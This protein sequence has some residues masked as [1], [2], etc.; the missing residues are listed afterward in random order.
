MNIQCVRCIEL[1]R[2]VPVKAWEMDGDGNRHGR[3]KGLEA[4]TPALYCDEI[5]SL[6]PLVSIIFMR[7]ESQE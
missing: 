4:F 2:G 5:P 3:A 6:L 7:R 1:A